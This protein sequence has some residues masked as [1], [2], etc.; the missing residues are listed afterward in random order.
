MKPTV[1]LRLLSCLL[2]LLVTADLAAPAPAKP[3][4][5]PLDARE[6]VTRAHAAASGAAWKRPLTLH[7]RGAVVL[8]EN[9]GLGRRSVADDYEMWRM[10]PAWNTTAHG[11]S[12]KVRID[13]DNAG[14]PMFQISHDGVNTCHQDGLVPNAKANAEGS[15]SF[16][17]GIIRF[18][19]YQGFSVTRLADDQVEGPGP[20]HHGT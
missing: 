15:E 10:F 11:A 13:A 7:L 1:V 20:D 2:P 14:T 9:G 8:Y 16:G 12:G 5:A 17:F 4:E 3:A 18:A 6:I 19:L